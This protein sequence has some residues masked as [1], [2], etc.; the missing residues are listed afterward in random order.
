MQVQLESLPWHAVAEYACPVWRRSGHYLD[1]E[2][3]QACREI[4]D[5]SYSVQGRRPVLANRYCTT[6]DSKKVEKKQESQMSY[7]LDRNQQ[8]SACSLC[9]VYTNNISIRNIP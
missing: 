3:N 7:F 1:P 8:R 5:L 2:F 6:G 4:T 9:S